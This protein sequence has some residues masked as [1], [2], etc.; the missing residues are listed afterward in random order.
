MY[1]GIF[2]DS[3]SDNLFDSNIISDSFNGDGISMDSSTSNTLINNTIGLNAHAGI[4]LW[5]SSNNLVYHN[6]LINNSENGYDDTGTNSWDNGTEGNY[7]S[8]YAGTDE[9]EDGIGDTP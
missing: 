4:G 6:N 3:C 2:L 7:W 8:D 9:D 5:G 1:Y